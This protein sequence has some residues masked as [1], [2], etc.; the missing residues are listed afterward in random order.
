MTA[1]LD[2]DTVLDE[3]IL[4]D[5]PRCSIVV[6][7]VGGVTYCSDPATW[8]GRLP[9]GHNV[10]VCSPHQSR[11]STH[12]HPVRCPCGSFCTTNDMQ[13]SAL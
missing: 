2:H 12:S 11:F 7:D 10:L 1:L 6:R 4:D 13:W 5:V 8:T 3:S 9:C